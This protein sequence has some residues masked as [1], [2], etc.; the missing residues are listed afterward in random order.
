[1][2]TAERTDDYPRIA[3]MD[4]ATAGACTG[5]IVLMILGFIVWWPLGSRSSPS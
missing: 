4:P 5:W 3:G 2:S 1:M